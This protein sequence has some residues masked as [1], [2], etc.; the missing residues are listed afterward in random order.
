MA[1]RHDGWL[2]PERKQHKKRIKG[3]VKEA[4]YKSTLMNLDF[5]FQ[6]KKA[7][8]KNAS[9]HWLTLLSAPYWNR[10]WLWALQR[11][12]HVSC[13]T[14][15]FWLHAMAWCLWIGEVSF[16]TMKGQSQS[17][18]KTAWMS[19][20]WKFNLCRRLSGTKALHI[21]HFVPENKRVKGPLLS[22]LLFYYL[23]KKWKS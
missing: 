13:T 5:P 23:L 2:P 12:N 11:L 21:L 6:D 17:E 10:C 16:D 19:S 3:I 9:L 20:V 14:T 1:K 22:R 15:T 18:P 4:G 7:F 8:L